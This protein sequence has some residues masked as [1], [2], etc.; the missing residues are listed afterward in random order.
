MC[1]LVR[2]LAR[3]GSG[4]AK[5]CVREPDHLLRSIAEVEELDPSFGKSRPTSIFFSHADDASIWRHP[6]SCR[7]CLQRW[8]RYACISDTAP[9]G[10]IG[11]CL[12]KLLDLLTLSCTLLASAFFASI[13]L[14]LAVLLSAI[15]SSPFTL[16]LQ[17]TVPRRAAQLKHL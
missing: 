6:R 11:L 13:D 17:S 14:D 15:H 7:K 12:S 5:F 8:V 4:A 10:S 9:V 3:M 2:V 1:S 16:A